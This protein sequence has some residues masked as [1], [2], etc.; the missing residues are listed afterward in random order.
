MSIKFEFLPHAGESILVTTDE[1]TMLI[2]GGCE[3]PFQNDDY[4]GEPPATLDHVVI[5]HIDQDHIKGII[6]LLEYP[7][8]FNKIK[9]IVFNEPERSDIFSEACS[10]RLDSKSQGDSLRKILKNTSSK[11]EVKYDICT[12]KEKEIIFSSKTRIKILSPS[13]QAL[14]ALYNFWDPEA[15]KNTSNLNS[16]ED[17]S[18]NNNQKTIGDLADGIYTKKPTLANN[19]SIAFILEHNDKSFLFLGDADIRQVT[20]SLYKY[21]YSSENPLDIEFVKLSHHGSKFNINKEFLSLIRT[22]NYII[23][24]PYFGRTKLPDRETIAIIAKYATTRSKEAL[25]IYITKD[26]NEKIKSFTDEKN[27]KFKIEELNSFNQNIF[28]YEDE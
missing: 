10:N 11:I 4:F 9:S 18:H 22:D 21:N 1:F 16:A 13:W 23:C 25:N 14:D 19:S 7:E 3:H 12:D 6:A 8:Y 28:Y 17:E 2:D 24:K 15:Y 26:S 27:Y 20:K 5:T